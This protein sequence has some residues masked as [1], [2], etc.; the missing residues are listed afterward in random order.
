M[1]IALFYNFF[2]FSLYFLNSLFSCNVKLSVG[3]SWSFFQNTCFHHTLVSGKN[4]PWDKVWCT[5]CLLRSALGTSTSRR[6]GKK[7]KAAQRKKLICS[8]VLKVSP[9]CPRSSSGTGWVW[10][11]PPQIG[12]D[13]YINNHICQLWDEDHSRKICDPGWDTLQLGQSQK[14]QAAEV[15]W[16]QTSQHLRPEILPWRRNI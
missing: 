3:L 14:R 4:R 7:S 15:Q 9:H 6:E 2:Y 16:P 1:Y 12:G 10:S 13:R 5:K 8:T 11:P